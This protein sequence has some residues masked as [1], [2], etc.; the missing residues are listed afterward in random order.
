M[1]EGEDKRER[2]GAGLRVS[3]RQ[4]LS[5]GAAAGLGAGLGAGSGRAETADSTAMPVTEVARLADLEPGAEVHFSYPDAASPAVLLRFD[6]A[7]EHGI[8]PDQSIVAFSTLCTHKGCPVAWNAEHAMLI[9]PCHWSSFDPAK[10]GRMVIGQASQGLPRI[11]L[12][13][14]DGAIRAI[15]VEGLIYGRQ[16]NTL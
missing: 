1:S 6:G 14:E 16:T 13:L 9:C 5:L 3:R 11:V 2:R 10:G 15:G 4:M 7:V 12:S 8:G